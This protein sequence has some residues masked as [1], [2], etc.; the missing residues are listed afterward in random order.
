MKEG[1]NVL[2]AIVVDNQQLAADVWELVIDPGPKFEVDRIA[3]GQFV[4]FEPLDPS[5]GMA[6][7]FSVSMLS[8]RKGTFSV[9]YKVVG[10]NTKAM[11]Q[12]K[13]GDQIK[14]WGPLGNPWNLELI[15]D[16]QKVWLVGGGIGIAPLLFFKRVL[17]ELGLAETKIFYGCPDKKD[18]VPITA[19]GLESV[20]IATDNGSHGYH[21]FVTDLFLEEIEKQK[22][23][24]ILVI[25]CGPEIMMRRVARICKHQLA[26]CY[27]ILETI[28]ACGI[29]SCKG[30]S[31]ETK[32]GIKQ[33]CHDG[34]VFAAEEVF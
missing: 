17:T 27:V 29:N 32:S 10:K 18:I 7:P 31:I 12:L 2:Q 3:P 22:S 34:P 11:S 20:I 5:S 6:R 26:D 30:C 19:Y 33:V 15:G 24:K 14:F 16:F 21:G 4:C 13:E 28:M 1:I 9:L 25:T 8:T 23:N